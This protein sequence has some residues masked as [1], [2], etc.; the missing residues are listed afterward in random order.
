MRTAFCYTV[1]ET[2][3]PI[4][5]ITVRCNRLALANWTGFA[6]DL[7]LLYG[8]LKEQLFVYLLHTYVY[9]PVNAF[10]R[11]V[12]MRLLVAHTE[13]LKTYSK[14]PDEEKKDWSCRGGSTWW[15]WRRRRVHLKYLIRVYCTILSSSII[16]YLLSDKL[17]AAGP[18]SAFESFCSSL[19]CRMGLQKSTI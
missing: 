7:S 18:V 3:P 11:S 13:R 1:R 10:P 6:R 12:K 17:P 8:P 14:S 15:W 9:V 19:V 2:N 4:I 16:S 5:I